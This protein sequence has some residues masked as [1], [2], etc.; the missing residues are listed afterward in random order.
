MRRAND[1]CVER[2]FPDQPRHALFSAV[3]AI[4]ISSLL[5]QVDL[6]Y[7]GKVS[8]LYSDSST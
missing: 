3:G 1:F 5:S 7:F 2:G 4:A 6:S 8:P